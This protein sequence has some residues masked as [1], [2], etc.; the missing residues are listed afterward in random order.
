MFYNCSKLVYNDEQKNAIDNIINFIS[1]DTNFFG[2]YGFAGTGKTTIIMEIVK[3]LLVENNFK[4]IA[5]T[6]PTNKAVNILKSKIEISQDFWDIYNLKFLT[7]HKLLGYVNDFSDEGSKIFTRGTKSTMGKYKLIVI[8]ECSMIPKD[9]LDLIFNEV[10]R[11]RKKPKIFFVGDP[12]QLPPV[13]EINSKIF[14]YET[15]FQTIIL[16]QIVR[17]TFIEVNDLWT[18]IRNWVEHNIA[19]SKIK[20]GEHVF[21]FKSTL[22]KIDSDWFKIFLNEI[23]AGK[24][25]IILTWTNK[26]TDLYNFVIRKKIFKTKEQYIINDLL[27]LNN[28]YKDEEKKL[29]TSEQV[30][31]IA[32]EIVYKKFD[33]IIENLPEYIVKILENIKNKTKMVYNIWKLKVKKI[34]NN[35]IYEIC[36]IHESSKKILEEDKSISYKMI[37][38]VIKTKKM[39]RDGKILWKCWND[40]F[41]DNFAEVNYGFSITT[42]KSQGS[43]FGDVFVD[44]ND[45]LTNSNENDA[46]RCLYTAITRA[47]GKIFLLI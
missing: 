45:I 32:V 16:K 2:L 26:Q 1:N 8:D 44:V 5:I 33:F 35:K 13:N 41:I 38:E 43:T 25:S 27:I 15:K 46:K 29:Y 10:K 40:T 21:V 12:A 11:M 23:N 9:M 17:N 3:Y 18:S 39:F 47:S 4:N 34:E 36:V 37:I 24:S 20:K 7:I 31:V 28:F 14:T 19:L 6:A 22:K 42:H 30:K